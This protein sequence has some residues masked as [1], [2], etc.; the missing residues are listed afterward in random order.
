MADTSGI[1]WGV[2]VYEVI[3][4]P[5]NSDGSL[6]AVD[7]TPYEGLTM[8]GPRAFDLTPSEPRV[9]NNPGS[10]RIMDVIYL[11]AN[12]ANRAEL[13]VGYN[14]QSVK[15]KLSGTKKFAVGES[16][17]V[18]R[19]TEQQ[20]NEPDVA[21]V[22]AQ[23]AKDENKLKRWHYYMIPRARAIPLDSPMNENALEERY[24][25]TM[26]PSTEHIWGKELSVA[27]EGCLEAAYADGM[28][29]GRPK[30]VA[31]LGNGI[32]DEFLFPTN[33][34]AIS[35][36]KISVFQFALGTEYTAGI[37]KATTGVTFAVAPANNLLIVAKYEY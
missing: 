23:L 14:N 37:T 16:T 25:I 27:T 21:I 2:D 5:L 13:R 24:S 30:I 29:E 19:G 11:P 34:Q 12:E 33:Y 4:F 9:V 20:G 18:M 17:M 26:S 3:V 31:W 36:A 35:T 1:V 32:E 22:A 10:G 8:R 28:S 15:A 7:T 6:Q